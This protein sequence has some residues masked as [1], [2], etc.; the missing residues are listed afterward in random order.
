MAYDAPSATSPGTCQGR[1]SREEL[2][3]HGMRLPHAGCPR[4]TPTARFAED[5]RT[6]ALACKASWP[7]RERLRMS[8]HADLLAVVSKFGADE[9]RVLVVLARRLLEGRKAARLR[10]S[11]R[12]AG[13]TCKASATRAND[14]R[15]RFTSPLSIFCQC[16]Q[17]MPARF[18]TSSNVKP[19]CSR[20]CRALAASF[21]RTLRSDAVRRG[22]HQR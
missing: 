16:R 17:W 1:P 5:G 3:A 10:Y 12:R 14:A 8:A 7:K 2:S 13:S 15:V 22:T 18:A 9:L 21:W 4:A 6:R 20:N 19:P 11:R